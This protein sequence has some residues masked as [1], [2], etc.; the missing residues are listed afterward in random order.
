MRTKKRV[1]E[2]KKLK[3]VINLQKKYFCKKRRKQSSA[4][5]VPL[6]T[7][8]YI[9]GMKESENPRYR[10]VLSLGGKKRQK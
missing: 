8:N 2:I 1:A 4:K 3:N 6:K 5:K 7:K 10:N 9:L